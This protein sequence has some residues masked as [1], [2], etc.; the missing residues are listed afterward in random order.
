MFGDFIKKIS[1]NYS[2][3][4][5]LFFWL[6]IILNFFALAN[7][8]AILGPFPLWMIILQGLYLGVC[9]L[10]YIKG[11]K[12]SYIVVPLFIIALAFY[13]SSNVA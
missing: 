1:K 12:L 13:L 6:A 4:E 10:A 3:I 2:K 8:I 9:L 5:H 7:A 11:Y